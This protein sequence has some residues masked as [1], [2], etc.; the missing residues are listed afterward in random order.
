[1][2]TVGRE[3]GP[4]LDLRVNLDV[5]PAAALERVRA[6]TRDRAVVRACWA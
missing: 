4:H 5:D 3:T 2:G 1:M 6:A